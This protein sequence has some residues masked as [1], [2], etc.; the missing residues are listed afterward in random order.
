MGRLKGIKIRGPRGPHYS[1]E[2]ALEKVYEIKASRNNKVGSFQ[3]ALSFPSILIG[4]K[5]KLVLV[6]K[7][8]AIKQLRKDADKIFGPKIDYD[9]KYDILSITWF[10]QLEYDSSIET[11]NGFVFDISKKPTQDV[12]GI[13]IFDFMKKIKGK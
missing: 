6:D 12:K 11:E 4:H 8:P 7:K 2:E 1:L 10:P 5:V 13:E 3:G 9:K